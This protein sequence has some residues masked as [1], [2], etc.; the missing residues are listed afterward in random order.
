MEANAKRL[1]DLR[2]A[3]GIRSLTEVLAMLDQQ[4]MVL[5]RIEDA[6]VGAVI[7]GALVAGLVVLYLKGQTK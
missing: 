4:A 2:E 1:G 7:V 6:I 5:K 3:E